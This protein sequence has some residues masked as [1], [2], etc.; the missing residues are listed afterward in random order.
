MD[1][2]KLTKVYFYEHIISLN[3]YFYDMDTHN[4]HVNTVT[5]I[6]VTL[7]KTK[8]DNHLFLN[9]WEILESSG[10]VNGH[11]FLEAQKNQH[12]TLSTILIE[13]SMQPLWKYSN[14]QIKVDFLSYI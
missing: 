12:P 2:I 6:W 10:L 13:K 5:F 8:W 11:Y 9:Q 1:K 3:R 14:P 7:C 4:F